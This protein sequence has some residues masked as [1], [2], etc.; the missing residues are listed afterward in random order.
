[1]EIEEFFE[2]Y[3]VQLE[4]VK[5]ELLTQHS[6]VLVQGS[7]GSGKTTLLKARS[8]YLIECEQIEADQIWN[9]AR[10][11]KSAKQMAR[12]FRHFYD[13]VAMPHFIDLHA[14]AY[15]I[16]KMDHEA[17]GISVWPAYRN[18]KS[19]VKKICKDMFALS[20]TNDKLD[21]VLYQI[22]HCKNMLMSE[23][24]IEKVQMEGMNFPA[25]YKMYEKNRKAKQFYDMDD[26]LV[27][28]LCILR[29][30]KD[31]LDGCHQAISYL[32]IDDAQEVSF[33][34]H[35][36]LRSVC[37]DHAQ[38]FALADKSQSCKKVSC[39]FPEALDTLD[40]AYSGLKSFTMDINYRNTKMIQEIMN[41]F[42]HETRVCA[43][44]EDGE[45][46]FKGFSNLD[47]VYSYAYETVSADMMSEH[48]FLYRNEEMALP[49]IDMFIEKEVAFYCSKSLRNLLKDTLIADMVGFIRL[50]S[51]AHD[52]DAF[53]QVQDHFHLDIPQRVFPEVAQCMQLQDMDIY[54]ALMDSSLR[55]VSKKKLAGRMEKIRLAAMKDTLGMISFVLKEFNYRTYLD[56][57][58]AN[59]KHPALLALYTMAERYPQPKD[60]VEHMQRIAQFNSMDLANVKICSIEESMGQEYDNVYV[61]DCMNTLFPKTG[62][63]DEYERSLFYIAMSRA[64]KHLEFFTFKKASLV[65]MELSGFLYEIY[66]QPEENQPERD[67][68]A[69]SQPKKVRL[70]DLKRGKKIIHAT[71]GLG[72]IMKI[73]DGMMHVQFANE[74]KTLNAKLCIQNDLID[75]P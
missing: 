1:M 61:L 25:I 50:L 51:N 5:K 21:E 62:V 13:G 24:Q 39:A 40:T 12:E 44:E 9:I 32:Q 19:F 10:D 23:S 58:Q 20:L 26:V 37:G 63:Y 2:S 41:K 48:V 59:E 75:L 8:A 69:E 18:V 60:F 45:V 56:K 16:I 33:A 70:S 53:I 49:L 71:L 3:N 4:D 35:M 34:G 38:L 47:R 68:S 73:S 36:L 17:K 6:H 55:A 27:E 28:A 57:H 72:R 64:L 29:S 31:V 67:T 46:K 65:K 66:Q 7:A 54:Q 15:K 14:L 30:D 22:A 43:S 42:A 11:G 52:L 74:L